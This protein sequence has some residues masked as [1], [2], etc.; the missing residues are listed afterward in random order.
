MYGTWVRYIGTKT[1]PMYLTGQTHVSYPYRIRTVPVPYSTCTRTQTRTNRP[2]P[3]I[4]HTVLLPKWPLEHYSPNWQKKI[5]VKLFRNKICLQ[6][7]A[8]YLTFY[9]TFH[10]TF[11]WAYIFW[12]SMW[13]SIPH[14]MYWQFFLALPW[15]SHVAYPYNIHTRSWMLVGLQISLD[16]RWSHALQ[17][18]VC[19]IYWYRKVG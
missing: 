14:I 19:Q 15:A 12:H 8:F 11:Y 10:L 7:L 2:V 5:L 13:H 18:V 6:C 1:V 16:L 17:H 3:I 4:W 9:L